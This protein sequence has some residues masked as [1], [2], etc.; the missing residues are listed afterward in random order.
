M[1][2]LKWMGRKM[3]KKILGEN[4][5]DVVRRFNFSKLEHYSRIDHVFLNI[6]EDFS[7]ENARFLCV[8]H[9]RNGIRAELLPRLVNR[10]L[11]IGDVSIKM[12]L[13]DDERPVVLTNVKF[14]K[15]GL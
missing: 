11:K 1:K 5:I 15:K 8:W 12:D 9:L 2:T 10:E 13:K 3:L 14:K 4:E 6:N 7:H